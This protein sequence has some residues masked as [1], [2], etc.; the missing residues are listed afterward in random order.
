M[1]LPKPSKLFKE[2]T[3]PNRMKKQN[4]NYDFPV[5]AFQRQQADLLF[6]PT[7]KNTKDKYLLVVAD[8]GTRLLD[9]EPISNKK[10]STVTKAYKSILKRKI[11]KLPKLL[12][13]DSGTE[14]MQDFKKFVESE[15]VIL[16]QGR[17]GR[18]QQVAI[19]ERANQSIGKY[20]NQI[21]TE[22]ELSTGKRN[23]EWVEYVKPLI[24]ILNAKRKRAPQI[25]DLKKQFEDFK[26]VK[27]PKSG[28]DLL[29]PDSMVRVQLE[30]PI[31]P[32]TGKKLGN[33]FRT[34]DIRFSPEVYKIDGIR[35]YSNSPPMY[36]IKEFNT[37]F[38][39]DELKLTE[40][41]RAKDEY[42]PSRIRGEKKNKYVIEWRGY[43]KSKDFTEESKKLITEEFPIL[44]KNW[45]EFKKSSP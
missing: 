7:D 5:V 36:Y 2:L 10:A 4:G 16:H 11:L 43:P 13:V 21:M 15:G 40:S 38:T 24:K 19:V 1:S 27:C 39:R 32:V 14:F 42:Y 9:A 31:D 8:V 25:P 23:T 12:T 22:K 33:K 34:G 3:T 44:V 28:C 20:L 30:Y 17:V 37:L 35:L 6:L 18:K 26:P 45:K 41:K 29:Y